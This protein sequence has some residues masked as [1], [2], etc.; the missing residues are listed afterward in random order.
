MH[1]KA[2]RSDPD[3]LVEMAEAEPGQNGNYSWMNNP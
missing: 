3:L 1:S 2:K